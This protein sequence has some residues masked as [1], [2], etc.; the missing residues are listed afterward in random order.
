MTTPLPKNLIEEEAEMKRADRRS[1]INIL[2]LGD[3]KLSA[4]F[5]ALIFF[6]FLIFKSVLSHHIMSLS[7]LIKIQREWENPL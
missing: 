2:V 1:S 6:R 3:R 7:N 5:L 4:Y